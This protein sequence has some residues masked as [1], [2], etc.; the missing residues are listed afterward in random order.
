ML[1]NCSNP[2]DLASLLVRNENKKFLILGFSF[3]VCDV[4]SG[5]GFWPFW[6][7]LPGPR[8]NRKRE[9]FLSIFIGNYAGIRILEPLISFLAFLV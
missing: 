9:V 7:R 1:V 4:I 6:I 8:P 5:V 3:F 2:Q